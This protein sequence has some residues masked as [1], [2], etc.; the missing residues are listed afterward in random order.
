MWI[1]QIFL[2]NFGSFNQLRIDNLRPRLTVILGR[3]EAGKSTILEFVRS[4]FFGFKTRIGRTNTYETPSG[5]PRK[6]WLTVHSAVEGLLRIERVEKRGL[7]EG[8]LTISDENG[9]QLEPTGIP[10]FHAGMDRAVYESLFAFD[11]DQMRHLDSETLRRKIMATAV[12]S[13]KVS[14][15]DV[16]SRLDDRV[17]TLGKKSQRDSEALWAIQAQIK[18]VDQK[19]SVLAEEP[20]RYSDLK[21]DLESVEEKRKTISD[22][23]RSTELALH[24]LNG[25]VRHEDAWKKL[26]SI[27]AQ[28]SDLTYAREFPVDGILRFE[29]MV[30]RRRD[31]DDS[32]AEAE[33]KLEQLN[34]HVETLNPDPIVLEHAQSIQSLYREALQL[35][36]RPPELEAAAAAL[37]RSTSEVAA[38]I[39]EFGLGWDQERV[40]TS[41]SSLAVEQEI[42]EFAA[43]RHECRER[44][45]HIESRITELSE[46]L[47]RAQA[48]MQGKREELQNL[49]VACESFLEP[50][51][52]NELLEWKQHHGRIRDIG[53]RLLEKRRTMEGLISTRVDMDRKLDQLEGE[54]APLVPPALFSLLVILFGG[55]GIGMIV[56]GLRSED[57]AAY[58]FT[59]IGF[60]IFIALPWIIRWKIIGERR[61]LANLRQM[62]D[63]LLDQQTAATK[64]LTEVEKERRTLLQELEDLKSRCSEI[65]NSVLKNPSAGLT[66][67]LRAEALSSA[68]EEPVRRRQILEDGLRS[69]LAELKIE[70][71]RLTEVTKL[72]EQA[73]EEFEQSD[74]RWKDFLI[75][76]SLDES[77]EPDAALDLV[78]RL[79]DLKGRLRRTCELEEAL[80]VLREEWDEFTGRVLELGYEMDRPVAAEISP[81]DQAEQWNIQVTESKEA[82]AEKKSVLERVVENQIRLDLLV[83]KI[84]EANDQIAALVGAA[85]VGDE[86]SFR[87]LAR[88][89]DRYRSLEQERTHLVANLVSGL[90]CRDEAAMRSQLQHQDWEENRKS[91]T[92]LQETLDRLREESNELAAQSGRLESEIS[93]LETEEE[94]EML[95][96]EKEE[97]L[98]RLNYAIKEWMTLKLATGLLEKT[99][100]VYESEKQP[101]MLE[102]GSEIFAE[103]TGHAYQKILLPL[104]SERVKVQ[105]ADG[106]RI[107]QDHL[108]RGTLEQVYLSL[109]LAH[110]DVYRRTDSA[111]PL[112]MDDVLVNFDPERA[113]RTAEVLTKFSRDSEIQVLFFTCHPHVAE[114]FPH[115]AAR[116]TLDDA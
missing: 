92:N 21:K 104:D 108:S 26:H 3:N 29:K 7:K 116:I 106:T 32:L 110:L 5:L 100:R 11:L 103:I 75:A 85:G 13:F 93:I 33:K 52:R 14:P 79:R 77:V 71:D 39:S 87:N 4:I 80:R 58:A 113:R 74:G 89:H 53:D 61:R 91:M 81:L 63:S 9:N 57:L 109:R 99:L 34:T 41:A 68:A 24:K 17:K 30:E 28:M 90:N 25:L 86:E 96:A 70:E 69:D 107:E 55:A 72:L 105:R 67:V 31:A 37:N 84:R 66:E 65:S 111:I 76:R 40:M 59:S 78:R 15:L 12:G 98:A 88:D 18:D 54:N 51:S 23:I 10:V 115:D 42:R 6:G 35:A 20:A 49:A 44:I 50:A 36:G 64:D 48:K 102:R 27:E 19:L 97:L 16:K 1:E 83:R 114:L 43:S 56:A 73:E 94:T 112:M 22:E 82:L 8:S 46:A 2:E 95:L 101:R 38:D 62:K 60:L 47:K 45:H